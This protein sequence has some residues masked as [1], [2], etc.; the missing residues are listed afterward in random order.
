MA[1]FQTSWSPRMISSPRATR[2]SKEVQRRRRHKGSLM[3]A[4]PTNNRVHWSEIHIY[5]GKDG[6][7]AE[8]W[9]KLAMM[10]LLQQTQAGPPR[11]IDDL[12]DEAG[13]RAQEA[14]DVA[15]IQQSS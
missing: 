2:S 7:I 3:G 6:K 11:I 4:P 12:L 15:A 1:P 14:L 13:L 8:Q 9:A 10:E 5:R